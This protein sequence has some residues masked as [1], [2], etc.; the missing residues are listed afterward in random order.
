MSLLTGHDIQIGAYHSARDF[1][2]IPAKKCVVQPPTEKVISLDVPG[3]N[4]QADLSHSITG[5][6]VFYER[7][8]A[9]EF[10]SDL[11]FNRVWT[12]YRDIKQKLALQCQTSAKI[13]LDDEPTFYYKG[14]VWMGNQPTQTGQNTKFTLNYRLYPFKYLVKPLEEDWLWDDFNF[15]TDLAPQKLGDIILTADSPSTVVRLPPT[16]KPAL[17]TLKGSGSGARYVLR[18]NN[19]NGEVIS[20]GSLFKLGLFQWQAKILLKPAA[21]TNGGM[22]NIYYLQLTK[23]AGDEAHVRGTYE[24]GYL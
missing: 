21:S 22:L 12:A 14:K 3:M 15:E 8:G 24:P 10:Y 16:D 18:Y 5:Y 11:D 13:I 7:E 19:E 20:Q 2:L 6:P 23:E 9:W 1:H 4:G 17:L